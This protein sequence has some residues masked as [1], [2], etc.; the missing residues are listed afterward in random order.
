MTSLEGSVYSV[1]IKMHMPFNS[2]I[3]LLRLHP[4]ANLYQLCK[5]VY[6]DAPYSI[7]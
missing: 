5:D 6:K 4:V 3:G 1:Q 2:A 7:A